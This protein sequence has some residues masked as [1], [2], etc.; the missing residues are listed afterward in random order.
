MNRTA[1]PFTQ[2][3]SESGPLSG[4]DNLLNLQELFLQNVSHE[5]RTPLNAVVGFAELLGEGCLGDLAPA[6]AEAVGMIQGAARTL[7][8]QV[9][10]LTL[11]LAAEAGQ[12]KPAELDLETLLDD[13]VADKVQDALAKE[14]DFRLHVETGLPALLADPA[15]LTTTLQA[16]LDNAVE[17]T[18]AGGRIDVGLYQD[19]GWLWLAVSDSGTGIAAADQAHVCD[20]FYQAERHLARDKSGLGLGLTLAQAVVRAS[21]GDLRLF[22]QP[23]RGT[24]VM[25][26]L[27]AINQL[28]T[29]LPLARNEP[30]PNKAERP[31]PRNPIP[32]WVLEA[33]SPALC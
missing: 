18:P 15:G 6:Q 7:Q 25:L 23:G 1:R 10:R 14:I 13:V 22:S 28:P 12:L 2:S 29:S 32:V 33:R 3:V 27:P 20:R 4:T 30:T 16:L 9:E 19:S 21:G 17:H 5:L 24:C 26:R 31:I 8:Q 11:L